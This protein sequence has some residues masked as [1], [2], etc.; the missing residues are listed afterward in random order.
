MVSASPTVDFT[1]WTP[2]H[3]DVP[4]RGRA[5]GGQPAAHQLPAVPLRGLIISLFGISRP[6][7][8]ENIYGRP[9]RAEI[10]IFPST[11]RPRAGR[12]ATA[13]CCRSRRTRRSSPCSGRL[14]G[15][16][17]SRTSPC[18]TCRVEGRCTRGRAGP[19]AARPGRDGR[20]GDRDAAG[21][22]DSGP[23]ARHD[24]VRQ[25]GRGRPRR[26]RAEP[27]AVQSGKGSATRPPPVSP[28]S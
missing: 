21:V 8:K 2:D 6:Q 18:P 23:L 4:D 24:C 1:S 10:R 20:L 26:A 12:G 25:P 13:S 5:S 27:R 19:L 9:F 28:S 16:T 7:L 14:T 17:A 22:G 11:S 15:E 3:A